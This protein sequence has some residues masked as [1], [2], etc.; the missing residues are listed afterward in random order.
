MPMTLA[1]RLISM[2]AGRD[3][4]AGE[5][6]VVKVD[7]AYVQDWTGPLTVDKINEL[8]VGLAKDPAKVAVFIDHS[9]PSY[10]KE[11]S[12]GHIKL[13]DYASRSGCMI[14]DIGEGVSHL[15]LGER[16][17]S[18]GMLM[19]G[20]DS[21]TCQGGALGA[22]C[23]GMGSTDVAVAIATGENW[24]LVPGAIK[25]EVTGRLPHG[26]YSKDVMLHLIGSVGADGATYCSLE[27]M[28]DTIDAMSLPARVTIASMAVEAGAK[29]GLF[30]TDGHTF[31]WLREN[32]REGDYKE[33]SHEPGA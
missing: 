3:A 8:G 30:A 25:V 2:H 20:A 9:S 26:V 12:T 32:R 23:T 1:E 33:I 7:F 13:R 10:V 4:R 21:H 15:V 27:F 18:P 16:V 28:G 31:E 11:I 14:F 24:M 29:C 19:V 6:H 5:L 17:T 22:F